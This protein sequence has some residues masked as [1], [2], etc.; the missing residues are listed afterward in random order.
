MLKLCIK[1]KILNCEKK[2][3]ISQINHSAN[4]D[5]FWKHRLLRS[6][7]K[8]LIH[9]FFE[10]QEFLLS[11]LEYEKRADCIKSSNFEKTNFYLKIRT[12][13]ILN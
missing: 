3:I 4:F 7:H 9:N 8:V 11:K 1:K 12:S 2:N 5:L 13:W 10:L 6:I